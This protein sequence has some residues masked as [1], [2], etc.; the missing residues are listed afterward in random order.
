MIEAITLP[1]SAITGVSLST[2]LLLIILIVIIR[3]D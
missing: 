3:K 2:I 1:I